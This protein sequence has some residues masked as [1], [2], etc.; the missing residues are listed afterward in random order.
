[1]LSTRSNAHESIEITG[2]ERLTSKL[3]NYSAARD[4]HLFIQHTTNTSLAYARSAC[5]QLPS[6]SFAWHGNGA[7]QGLLIN[8]SRRKEQNGGE[9][10]PRTRERSLNYQIVA[11]P[12]EN[13]QHGR[14]AAAKPGLNGAR[15]TRLI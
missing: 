5:P 14:R 11:R 8:S 12:G 10:E 13:E 2:T 7:R 4:V 3:E 6:R 15:A 1:M 9:N